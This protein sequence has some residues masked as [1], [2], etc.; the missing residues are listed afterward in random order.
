MVE[1][2]T[3]TSIDAMYEAGQVVARALTAVR[4]TAD[5]GVSLLKLDEIAHQVL[6]DA[7]AGSPFL[8]Y[9]PSFAPT[10]FP[11][12]ICSSVN[13]A[14]VHGIPTDYRLCDGDLVSVD[15]GA[16]LGGW[17]GDSAIS[18]V[19]G[20]PRV[21]D[22]RLIETAERA[23][24]AGIEA[25]VVGN[26]IGDIAHAIG[27]VCRAAGYGIPDG[28]GGHGIGRSMHEEPK[29]A[30]FVT[31]E[32]LRGDFLLKP[33]MTLAVEP[34]VV[35]G[36]RDVVQLEDNWTIVTVDR[37]PAAHFEHTVA[38]SE[39]GADILTDGRPSQPVPEP[40]TGGAARVTG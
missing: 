40:A 19:V 32:Q 33:G 14:I 4:E 8:G 29:V 15:F 30:N 11:A 26:R 28:F 34:M 36:R 25:A 10:P 7:G 24:A 18:F 6:R 16:E 22:V 2:K 27:T 12:V 13:N 23:L 20:E 31:G 1:L 35:M 38:V 21:A 5:V 39:T 3:D 9:R 17:A 37:M